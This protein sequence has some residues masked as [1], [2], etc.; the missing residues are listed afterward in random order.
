M[1][2]FI[3]Q[4]IT[5]FY[6]CFLAVSILFLL[7]EKGGVSAVNGTDYIGSL[8]LRNKKTVLLMINICN[9]AGVT[10]HCTAHR[11]VEES[12][13]IRV[14]EEPVVC[15]ST[16]WAARCLS[17]Y[18]PARQMLCVLATTIPFLGC[19]TGKLCNDKHTPGWTLSR[20]HLLKTYYHPPCKCHPKPRGHG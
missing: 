12:P 7:L 19:R 3:Q 6:S 2:E 9:S 11:W 14:W 5:C 1:C 16:W 13:A 8:W 10:S 20:G 4:K 15:S 17:S 18:I